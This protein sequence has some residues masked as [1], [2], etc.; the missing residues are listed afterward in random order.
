MKTRR[1]RAIYKAL[2]RDFFKKMDTMGFTR[3]V[4]TK[5]TKGDI[6]EMNKVVRNINSQTPKRNSGAVVVR[7]S[8]GTR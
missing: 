1:H 5:L 7:D 2:V 8:E 3:V 6:K 4:D